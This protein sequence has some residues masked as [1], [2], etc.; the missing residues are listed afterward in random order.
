V[1]P[2]FVGEIF[3]MKVFPSAV[4]SL[5]LAFILDFVANFFEKVIR[6]SAR[7][8]RGALNSALV[9]I[10]LARPALIS[11][12]PRVGGCPFDLFVERK[13][14]QHIHTND[15]SKLSKLFLN[16]FPIFEEL[17]VLVVLVGLLDGWQFRVLN[18]W[19]FKGVR[20]VLVC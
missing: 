11:F 7:V 12:C 18:G 1:E 3:R 4:S 6:V 9:D 8:D 15:G 16:V 19:Q 13:R 10:E 2:I 20:L 17:K 14:K 5:S